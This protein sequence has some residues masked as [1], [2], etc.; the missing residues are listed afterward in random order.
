MTLILLRIGAAAFF[1]V[2]SLFVVLFRVSPLTTPGVALPLLFLT[3]FLSAASI[4]SLLAY[5]AWSQTAL[6][7]MDAGKKL[8]VALREGIFFASATVLVLAFH[9]LGIL[10]WWIAVMMYAVF[11]LVEV[12][13]HS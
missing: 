7:G 8:S 11:L 13:L 6:E 4:M 2:T 12:A 5:G 9:V 10:T 3:V 1:S